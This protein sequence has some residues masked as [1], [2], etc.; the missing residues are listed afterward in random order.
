MAVTIA[1]GD[2]PIEIEL[3]KHARARRLTLRIPASGGCPILTAPRHAS[4]SQ[5]VSFAKRNEPWLRDRMDAMDPVKTPE[6]GMTIPFRGVD[7]QI[8]PGTGRSVVQNGATL[9]VPGKA[10]HVARKLAAF[11]KVS[12]RDKLD[13]AV[14]RYA[15]VLNVTPGTLRLRD[16]R[17][18]WGSCSSRGDLMF[19]WRLIMAPSDVLEY[20][21]AHEVAHLL[22]M[23]HSAAFWAHV[24]RAYPGW[25]SRRDWLRQEGSSLHR[26]QF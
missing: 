20:V 3:R 11:L 19:S 26:F 2:P 13:Q 8:V 10:E 5:M 9:E 25:E 21:A 22:E 14:Q 23:N 4:Q 17:S 7:M 24:N 12:A 16:T 15:A 6:F 18:R 1:L